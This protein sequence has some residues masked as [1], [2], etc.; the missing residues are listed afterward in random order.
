MFLD[1]FVICNN[2]V[3]FCRHNNVIDFYTVFDNRIKAKTVF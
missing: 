1:K 2:N 3:D